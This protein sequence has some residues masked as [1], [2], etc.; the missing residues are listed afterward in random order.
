MCC[1]SLK[2]IFQGTRN[3]E[4]VL[5]YLCKIGREIDDI[6]ECLFE[7]DNSMSLFAM[8]CNAMARDGTRRRHVHVVTWTGSEQ[9]SVYVIYVSHVLIAPFVS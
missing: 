1:L 7:C 8:Q 3:I 2:P 6:D 9:N 5:V 4:D